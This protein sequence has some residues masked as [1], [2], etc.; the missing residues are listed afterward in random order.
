M[1]GISKELQQVIQASWF[2]V[3]NGLYAYAKVS[4]VLF[5]L[6]NI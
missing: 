2:T 1:M 4:H 5:L 3:E 6:K